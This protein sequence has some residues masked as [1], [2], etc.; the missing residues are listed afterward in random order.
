VHPDVTGGFD[1]RETDVG[2]L[3]QSRSL[4]GVATHGFTT[5]ARQF[6][7]ESE[8]DDF[9]DLARALGSPD[10]RV[11]RVTQ[12]HG[13]A[14]HTVRSGDATTTVE[15][16]AI[17]ALVPGCVVAVRTADCVPILLADQGGAAVAAIH[18]GWRGA[19]GGVVRATVD[20]MVREGIDAS[21]LVAAIGPAIGPCCYQVGDIVRDSFLE[22][23]Q[24]ALSWFVPDG[25]GH[26]RL[27]LWRSTRDQLVAAGVDPARIAVSGLCT[28]HD[29]RRWFS[30]RRE[31]PG[32]GRLVAA[33]R[34]GSDLLSTETA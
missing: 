1:W 25:P 17:V 34:R 30:F 12:V 23:E 28:G 19:C 31:G 15:A 2:P 32:T 9:A 24:E 21:T 6:R 26:W 22:V 29:L 27:D 3:L 7:A 10:T 8:A 4:A 20:A 13:H 33:I 18:A 16:D 14:V 5:R 11:T